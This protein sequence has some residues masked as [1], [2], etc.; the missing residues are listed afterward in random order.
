VSWRGSVLEVLRRTVPRAR[1]IPLYD[2][3]SLLHDLGLSSLQLVELTTSIDRVAGR[4]VP[5]EEWF[6][7]EALDARG[8]LGS[9]IR[10]LDENYPRS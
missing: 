6:M 2:S 9:L 8:E 3:L 4:R 10:W 7:V 1:A 5:T